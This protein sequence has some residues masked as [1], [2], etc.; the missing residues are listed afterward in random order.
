MITASD[1]MSRD[2]EYVSESDTIS[3]AAALMA[4]LGARA[5]PI[6]DGGLKVIGV[7]SDRDI[8]IEGLTVYRSLSELT[9]KCASHRS[10]TVDVGAPLGDVLDLLAR[11]QLRR[12]PVTDQG[13]LVGMIGQ[14]E[15]ARHCSSR[16]IA[17]LLWLVGL[18]V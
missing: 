17:R 7:V 1:A 13:T 11:R 14:A 10:P 12:I 5:L 18:D 6:C 8:V 16:D 15:V 4:R 3:W 9:V 2:V